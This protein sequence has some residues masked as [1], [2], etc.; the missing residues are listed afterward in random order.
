MALTE[1]VKSFHVPETP[2]TTAWPP[3]FPSVPT[4]RATRV[5][6]DAKD[7]SWSTIVLIVFLSS[8]TSPFISTVIFLE[9]SP[10]A[11]AVVT[12]AMFLTWPVRFPAMEFTESV[13]SFHVP[14]TPFT[15]AWPPS[16]PSVPTSRATRVTSEA[17][18]ESCSTILLTVLA[19]RRNSPSSARSS[20]SRAMV[21]DRSPWATAPITR[22][23]SLV[24]WTRSPISALTEPIESFQNPRTSPSEARTLS[25]PSLPTRWR[26][27]ASSSA[28]RPFRSTTSLKVSASLPCMPV[29]SS[30]RRTVPSPCFSA[31]SADRS[32]L[33][34]RWEKTRSDSLGLRPLRSATAVDPSCAF[35]IVKSTPRVVRHAEVALDNAYLIVEIAPEFFDGALE[36]RIVERAGLHQVKPPGHRGQRRAKVVRHCAR[37]LSRNGVARLPAAREARDRIREDVGV[38]I[39]QLAVANHE[40]GLAFGKRA[41]CALPAIHLD[42]ADAGLLESGEYRLGARPPL[43]N[44]QDGSSH[45]S[46]EPRHTDYRRRIAYLYVGRLLHVW[47]RM[48]SYNGGK[49]R[50]QPSREG[51]AIW[52]RAPRNEYRIAPQGFHRRRLGRRGR[53]AGGA[54]RA[55]GARQCRRDGR[56]GRRGGRIHPSNAP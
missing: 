29:H 22:A 26:R 49:K 43:R 16:L 46:P 47:F 34:S 41:G 1:S 27:C 2:S 36:P 39:Q 11:T 21:C 54:G 15:R 18:E 33:A 55:A 52:E 53:D 6:S 31:T 50:E 37:H 35:F 24:G 17:N 44:F 7:R 3:S 38:G 10:V 23:V 20:T 4:S 9:R 28:M 14:A 42:N 13:R 12:S 56:V 8:S 30:G 19:V 51:T 5:T 25:L 48:A 40:R 45:A 32:C